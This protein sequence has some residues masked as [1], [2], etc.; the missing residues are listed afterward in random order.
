MGERWPKMSDGKELPTQPEQ[1]TNAF[2]NAFSS[3]HHPMVFDFIMVVVYCL[4]E[5]GISNPVYHLVQILGSYPSCGFNDV[6]LHERCFVEM[7]F[8]VYGGWVCGDM[9]NTHKLS[10]N[11]MMKGYLDG[12][13]PGVV[14]K[15]FR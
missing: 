8:G 9:G 10:W 12:K 6:A 13:N 3:P 2:A 11:V 7:S 15:L 4:A 14:L 5:G 1:K